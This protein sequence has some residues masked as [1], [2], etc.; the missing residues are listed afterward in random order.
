MA[1][2]L[3][4]TLLSDI[5]TDALFR[6]FCQW[7]D[8]LFLVTGGWTLSSDSGQMVIA[9]A[10]HPTS[11][12]QS[13]G[14]RIYCMADTLQA[15]APIFLKIEYGS[16]GIL[17][18]P[19]IWFTIGQGS[20]GSGTITNILRPRTQVMAGNNSSVQTGS[21]NSYGSAAPNRC[22]FGMFCQAA[23][24]IYPFLFSIERT[25]DAV[26]NDT[27]AGWIPVWRSQSG[28]TIG[29]DSSAY[30]INA[31]GTQPSVETGLNYIITHRT[32]SETFAPGDVGVGVI[33]PFKGV[34]QQPGI[35]WLVTNKDDVGV[36]GFI[37]LVIYGT[38]HVY[39]QLNNISPNKSKS[40]SS[41]YD[42]NARL[43]MRY[44]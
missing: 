19:G 44:D 2:K 11:G 32:P 6:A 37:N 20:N 43:L 10:V 12:N 21:A 9:S 34:A 18:E 27:A 35:N 25:K 7:I 31:V 30:V 13:M 26:G 1:T 40:G 29:L 8:D 39:Q 42:G 4:A 28:G 33:I 36:E 23:N 41:T 24:T 3:S 15:T 16:S 38:A 14:Y 17:V 22:C 5:T